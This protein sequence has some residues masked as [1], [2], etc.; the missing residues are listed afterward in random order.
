MKVKL[1]EQLRNRRVLAR[2]PGYVLCRRAGMPRARLSDIERG[3]VNPSVQE[4][5]QVEA[6]LD[7]LISAREKVTQFA[8]QCGWPTALI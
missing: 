6:A 3:H 4:L 5:A 7:K 8:S 1:V 2:I